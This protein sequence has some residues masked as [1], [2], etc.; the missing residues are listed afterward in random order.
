MSE[1]FVTVLQLNLEH[2]IR[3]CLCDDAFQFDNV[4]FRQSLSQPPFNLSVVVDSPTGYRVKI[5]GSPFV[6]STVCS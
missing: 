4:I 6:I 5:S 3:Q 1:D 2:R